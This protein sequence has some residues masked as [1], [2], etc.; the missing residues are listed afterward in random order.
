MKTTILKMLAAAVVAGGFA[1]SASAQTNVSSNITQDTTWTKANSPYI[2]QTIIYVTNGAELTIEPGVVIRGTDDDSAANLDIY[3]KDPGTLVV[4]RGASINANGTAAEPI[5]FTDEFDD[6][7]NGSS[8]SV[9]FN[10]NESANID[11]SDINN[12]HNEG[13]GGVIILGSAYVSATSSNDGS[14]DGDPFDGQLV[15]GL[16]IATGEGQYGGNAASAPF[17]TA[18]AADD[19]DSSGSLSF[20]S[21]RYGGAVLG[22][23]NEINGFTL[24]A[25]GVNT[26]INFIEVINNLD[27]GIEWFG[28]TVNG[29]YLVVINSGDDSFDWDEGFRGKGQYWLAIQGGNIN[30]VAGGGMHN[31]VGELDGSDGNDG[32]VPFSA[33]TVYNATFVGTAPEDA[34]DEHQTF[35]GIYFRDGGGGR[36]INS[37]FM[38]F[39]AGIVAIEEDADSD[40]E[41]TGAG[42]DIGDPVTHYNQPYSD[43]AGDATLRALS[44]QADPA[45][46]LQPFYQHNDEGLNILDFDSNLQWNSGAQPG[47]LFGEATA[48]SSTPPLVTKDFNSG[49]AN[50]DILNGGTGVIRGFAASAA[51]PVVSHTTTK[52]SVAHTTGSGTDEALL[53]FVYFTDTIDPRAAS[54]AATA[55]R[56][57]ADSYFDDVAYR[58]AFGPNSDWAR[59][60]TAASTL[61]M[62]T[63]PASIVNTVDITA[64]NFAFSFTSEV[65]KS[66]FI[67]SSSS[68]A[69]PF[70]TIDNVTATSTTTV[71]L[72]LDSL[73]TRQFYRVIEL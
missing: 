52:S 26:E 72:D 11:Y 8:G 68:P 19:F 60:W 49:E 36:I 70:T 34:A 40:D 41:V 67:Q 2:L 45:N 9:V 3:G 4:A 31:H 37:V 12:G 6:A 30:Q 38:N 29:K 21:I 58:G 20:W 42:T 18:L 10:T 53:G 62:I 28:G 35:S 64:T 32:N 48:N 1:F 61:G 27:D 51:L 57:P 59:G 24:G 17:T 44:V 7:V 73:T 65:G 66:Y 43:A 33:P 5:V 63:T 69:G 14:L 25:L 47:L 23:A 13:A 55:G 15:E 39:A 46:S 16:D 56:T 50:A 22:T 71:Y 54:T